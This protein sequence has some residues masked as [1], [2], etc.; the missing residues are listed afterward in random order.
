MQDNVTT[1]LLFQTMS[2]FLKAAL[3]PLLVIGV[4]AYGLF[5]F[6]IAYTVKLGPML[7]LQVFADERRE[8]TL[9]LGT[10]TI[11]IVVGLLVAIVRTAYLV[12]TQEKTD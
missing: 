1:K 3:M 9:G 2:A 12:R 4:I 6:G 5:M 8:M 11:C 10:W 7:V